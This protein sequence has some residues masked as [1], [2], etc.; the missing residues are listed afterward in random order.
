[1]VVIRPL[2][3]TDREAVAAIIGAHLADEWSYDVPRHDE[4]GTAVRVA[5]RDGS[6]VGVM[7]LSTYAE[8]AA[9]GDAMHLFETADPIPAASRYG[10]VHAGYVAPEHTGEGIGSR[11]LDRLHTVGE[12]AGVSTFVAD[13]WFHGGPDSPARL[14]SSHGYTVV[15]TRSIAGHADG[16]CPKCGT[17]CVCEAGLAVRSVADG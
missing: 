16:S 13:A 6:P 9:V 8:A 4:E 15:R 2:R 7:A 1:M 11:L 17:P 3:P 5:E 12:D 14:L 10:L